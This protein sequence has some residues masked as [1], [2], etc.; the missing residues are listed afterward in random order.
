MN[1]GQFFESRKVF[2]EEGLGTIMQVKQDFDTIKYARSSNEAEY[3]RISDI[4]GRSVC[5][6][7]T[8]MSLDDI[9][10]DVCRIMLID[11]D[12]VA[13]PRTVVTDINKLRSIAPLFG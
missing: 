7:I 6:D 3:V 12:G 8:A 4:L 5:L 2:I 13:K 11:D 1:R 9:F 10:K